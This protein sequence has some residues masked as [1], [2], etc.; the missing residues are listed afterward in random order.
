VVVP[1]I[2]LVAFYSK[3]KE[4]KFNNIVTS[5]GVAIGQKEDHALFDLFK[6]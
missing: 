3:T 2:G 1:I 6:F 5:G 4:E